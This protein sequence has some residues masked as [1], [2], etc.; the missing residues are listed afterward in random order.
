MATLFN[1]KGQNTKLKTLTLMQDLGFLEGVTLGT[2]REL[3]G[4][5]LTGEF[6]AFV[7]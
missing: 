3:R 5:G 7:N 2:R 4:S 6:Y 1:K